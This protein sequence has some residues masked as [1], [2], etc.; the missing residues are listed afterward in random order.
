MYIPKRI[1]TRAM[2]FFKLKG[3]SLICGMARSPLRIEPETVGQF[4]GQRDKKGNR[5]FEGDL[6]R[7]GNDVYKVCYNEKY[8]RFAYTKPNVIFAG[9]CLRDSEVV[10]NIYDNPEMMKGGKING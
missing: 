6:V 10:G 2:H 7:S 5:I 3:L 9:F 4:T 8:G 1:T